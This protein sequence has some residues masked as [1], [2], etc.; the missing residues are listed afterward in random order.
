MK[1]FIN[2]LSAYSINKADQMKYLNPHL[3]TS[4]LERHDVTTE[5]LIKIILL[6]LICNQEVV[7]RT[8]F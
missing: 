1:E 6:H 4:D 2:D 3:H 5:S 7:I 8:Q